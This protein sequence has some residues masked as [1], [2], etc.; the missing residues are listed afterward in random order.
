MDQQVL[1]QFFVKD[2]IDVRML[3]DQWLIKSKNDLQVLMITG[4]S[5]LQYL[6][7]SMLIQSN[8]HLPSVIHVTVSKHGTFADAHSL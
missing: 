6:C 1:I 4:N 3:P 7:E 5:S 2:T 8:R